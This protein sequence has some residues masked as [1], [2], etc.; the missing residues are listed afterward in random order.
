MIYEIYPVT[1]VTS[2][3][4][5]LERNSVLN[6]SLLLLAFPEAKGSPLRSAP[7]Y[8]KD[9]VAGV[10]LAKQWLERKEDEREMD[11]S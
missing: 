4:F 2:S 9:A 8:V 5:L 3:Q 11:R 7:A 1:E 10:P 6:G